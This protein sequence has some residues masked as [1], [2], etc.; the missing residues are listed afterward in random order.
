MNLLGAPASRRP[1]GSRKPEL[2]GE[3]PALP[4]IVPRFRG[5][6]REILFRRNLTPALSPVGDGGEGAATDRE[7][8]S[9]LFVFRMN[10]ERTDP[11]IRDCYKLSPK[12]CLNPHD[13]RA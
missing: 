12:F 13:G 8:G 7:D 11:A 2:A 1:V 6:K 4:G 10:M 9:F 3:T 5:S